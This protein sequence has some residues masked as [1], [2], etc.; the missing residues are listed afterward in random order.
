FANVRRTKVAGR[1]DVAA[2]V[3]PRIWSEDLCPPT[4]ARPYLNDRHA[5]LQAPECERFDRVTILVTGAVLSRPPSATGDLGERRMSR[6][7]RSVPI[8][9]G[10]ACRQNNSDD[11][12][13]KTT[14]RMIPQPRRTA[15]AV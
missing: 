8:R 9:S 3:H 6:G 14:H 15:P 7:C 1:C 12:D 4:S 5:R 11:A 2:I 13:E 10:G